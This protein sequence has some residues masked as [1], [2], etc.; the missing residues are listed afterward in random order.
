MRRKPPKGPWKRP[1]IPAPEPEVDPWDEIGEDAELPSLAALTLGEVASEPSEAV[2]ALGPPIGCV[3]SV[4]EWAFQLAATQAYEAAND[5]T[6]SQ[7]S[8][9]GRVRKMLAATARLYPEALRQEAAREIRESR[10]AVEDRKKNRRVSASM[11]PAPVAE[12]GNV[13]QFRGTRA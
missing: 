5:K 13:I 9:E 6:C 7:E 3:R 4:A 10:T 1:R 11:E 12:G 2:R 8:R